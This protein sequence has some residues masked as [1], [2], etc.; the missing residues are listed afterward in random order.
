MAA[1]YALISLV[2]GVFAAALLWPMGPIAAFVGASLAASLGVGATSVVVVLW[3]RRPG[4]EDTAP[5]PLQAHEL[6]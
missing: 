5:L 4:G 1:A 2:F 6:V 3:G